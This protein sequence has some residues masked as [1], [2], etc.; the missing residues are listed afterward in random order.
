M[1][2]VGKDAAMPR[3][4]RPWYR[5]D[6]DAWYAWIGGKRVKLADGK[7]GHDAAMKA[8]YKLK[9]RQATTPVA[10][11][12]LARE[13]AN[14]YFSHAQTHLA[15]LTAQ[16]Y[17]RH[18][19]SFAASIGDKPASE[20]RP[21]DVTAWVAS[22][23]E[24]NATTQNGAITAVK[25]AFRWAA[26]QGHIPADPV[27]AVEKP[28]ANRREHIMDAATIARV[29]AAVKDRAFLDLLTTLR[30]TGAR[31]SEVM[32]VR[33][34][35]IQ[36]DRGLWLLA[37][38]TTRRTGKMREVVLTDEVGAI[39]RRLIALHPD[40]PI[41]RNAKGR[42]W[43]RNAMACRFARLR[44]RLGLGP[45]ATA[46]S[47]RH[48]LATDLILAGHSNAVVAKILGH[49]STAMVDRHYSHIGDHRDHLKDVLRSVRGGVNTGS[50]GPA[51]D[52][53]T[54]D[55]SRSG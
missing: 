53:T 43:T 28:T 16:F 30:D 33:A 37:S 35:D 8:F 41:F 11:G 3:P 51:A 24:W 39:C 48:R 22:H 25:R 12:L 52:D 10:G 17:K 2:D 14:L 27:V 18:L 40:G 4:S 6:R 44:A 26:R 19:K 49:Q 21:K 9:A 45:E 31:P 23:P 47:F 29:L 36:L 46:E 13:V 54:P 55:A 1:I 42:P 38:K 32:K 50:P 7:D 15:P 20:V 34:A 5:G